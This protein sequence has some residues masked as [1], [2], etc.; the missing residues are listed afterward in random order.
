MTLYA[1]IAF[2]AVVLIFF[3]WLAFRYAHAAGSADAERKAFKE[4][5]EHARQ[6][7][8]IDE[9]VARLDD[10]EL[11]RELYGRR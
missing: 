2:G 8:E 6:A 11:D 3:V 10:G 5:T 7:N 1:A 4:Q 9:D